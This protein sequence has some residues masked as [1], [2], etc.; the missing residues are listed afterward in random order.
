LRTRAT[1]NRLREILRH[2]NLKT[3]LEIYAKAMSEDKLAA[4]GMFLEQLFSQ[5]QKKSPREVVSAKD[6]ERIEPGRLLA[7]MRVRE[8]LPV[9]CR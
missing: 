6:L 9:K 7:A 3:T 4:Q 5:D 2:Q 1:F 8:I